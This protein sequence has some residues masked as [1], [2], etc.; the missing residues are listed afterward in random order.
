[1]KY[2]DDQYTVEKID[3]LAKK[4]SDDFEWQMF[5][6][7][8]LSGAQVYEEIYELMR[9]HYLKALECVC[10]DEQ[11]ER[12]LVQHISLTYLHFNELL[13]PRNTN[14]QESLFWKMLAE[15]GT[16]DRRMRWLEVANF[17]SSYRGK[18][19][20]D[21]EIEKRILEFWSWTYEQ[22]DHVKNILGVCRTFSFQCDIVAHP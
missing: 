1:M 4:A 16:L 5:M 21:G 13:G 19:L 3:I 2:F 12:R 9:P 17:F 15:A 7:G 8:Y 18:G 10:F 22:R 20:K 14:G 6:D 11:A